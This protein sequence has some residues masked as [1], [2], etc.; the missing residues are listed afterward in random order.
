MGDFFFL[1]KQLIICFKWPVLRLNIKWD[2]RAG[3][4]IIQGNP[5]KRADVLALLFLPFQKAAVGH[6]S[7]PLGLQ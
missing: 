4:F 6:A 3:F 7:F 5:L 1:R 2:V